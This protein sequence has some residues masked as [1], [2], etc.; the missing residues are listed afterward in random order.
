MDNIELETLG[1]NFHLLP[2]FGVCV[3]F[4]CILAFVTSR[5]YCQLLFDALEL[6]KLDPAQ[7]RLLGPRAG[8]PISLPLYEN[9]NRL[10][11]ACGSAGKVIWTRLQHWYFAFLLGADPRHFAPITSCSILS[12][13]PTQSPTSLPSQSRPDGRTDQRP[14]ALRRPDGPGTHMIAFPF[15]SPLRVPR[16]GDPIV[17]DPEFHE[18][19]TTYE[20]SNREKIIETNLGSAVAAVAVTARSQRASR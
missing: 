5:P 6:V 17:S 19:A 1:L 20:C 16:R 12:G 7:S 3:V 2:S 11:E 9:I 15:S 10:R 13:N 14:P 4:A 8:P 18:H